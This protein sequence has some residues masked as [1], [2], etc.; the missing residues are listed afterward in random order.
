METAYL[1]QIQQY[2]QI[3]F[4]MII[5]PV[6]SFQFL[7]HIITAYYDSFEIMEDDYWGSLGGWQISLRN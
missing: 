3:N 5:V 2:K 1:E 7:V 6:I 4:I